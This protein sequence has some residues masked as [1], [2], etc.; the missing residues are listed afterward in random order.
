MVAA[1]GAFARWG[2]AESVRACCSFGSERVLSEAEL[3]PGVVDGAFG[4]RLAGYQV[5]FNGIA[6]PL[7]YAGPNQFN[8]VAPAAIVGLKSQLAEVGVRGFGKK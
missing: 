8:V 6:A 3:C 1:E 4:N 7:L 5:R 2:F